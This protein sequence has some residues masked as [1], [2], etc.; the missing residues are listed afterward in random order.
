VYAH[1]VSIALGSHGE[2][3]TCIEIA[4]RLKYLTDDK[5]MPLD[6]VLASS[7]RLLTALHKSLEEKIRN[8]NPRFPVP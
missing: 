6:K 5:R 3:E 7:G 2:L 8:E 1:H 4:S